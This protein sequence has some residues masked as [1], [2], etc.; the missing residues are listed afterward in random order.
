MRSLLSGIKTEEAVGFSVARTSQEKDSLSSGSKLGELVPSVAGSL[1]GSDS[2][3][4]LSSEFEGNDSE[5]FG[6]VEETDVVGD[7]TDDGYDSFELVILVLRVAVVRKVFD[8]AGQRDGESSESGLVKTLV[9]DLVEL[10]IS[11]SAE[12]GV[13]LNNMAS[14]LM[15]L[16]R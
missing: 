16:L 14:T 2:S 13:E 11:S 6:D 12:E 5:S 8:D 15:R 3:S 1:V 10:G 9:N 4:G 7:A